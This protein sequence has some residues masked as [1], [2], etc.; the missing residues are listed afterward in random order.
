MWRAA[1]V[2]SVDLSRLLATHRG[3][4]LPE[5]ISSQKTPT[6]YYRRRLT[7][8]RCQHFVFNH[9][10]C[11]A[12]GSQAAVHRLQRRHIGIHKVCLQRT[13][14]KFK[15]TKMSRTAIH[16]SVTQDR[17]LAQWLRLCVNVSMSAGCSTAACRV[18]CAVTCRAGDGIFEKSSTCGV[19]VS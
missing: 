10:E 4:Q 13:K 6:T 12:F 15:K 11:V 8:L 3:H 5:N 7:H 19:A 14:G 9:I 18:R 17:Y 2:R 1:F 16:P